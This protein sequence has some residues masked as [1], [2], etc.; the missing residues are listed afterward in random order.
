MAKAETRAE[1]PVTAKLTDSAR[2]FRM[3][4]KEFRELLDQHNIPV[5]RP[6]KRRELIHEYHLHR[7][8]ELIAGGA[9]REPAEAVQ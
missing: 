3:T 7:L 8:C 2:A 4:P 5:M 9:K 1:L 6:S